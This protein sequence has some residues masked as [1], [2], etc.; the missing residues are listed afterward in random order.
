M[1]LIALVPR[2]PAP[3]RNLSTTLP[4]AF[5]AAPRS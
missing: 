2:G 5:V 4:T 3:L 1:R